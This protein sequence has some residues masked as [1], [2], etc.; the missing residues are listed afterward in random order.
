MKMEPG[1]VEC[2]GDD[3]DGQSPPPDPAN[4]H[5]LLT[6]LLMGVL[7]RFGLVV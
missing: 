1:K 3:S 4:N 7:G 6:H 2:W 5:H